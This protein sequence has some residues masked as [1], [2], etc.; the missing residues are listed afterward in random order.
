MI[1]FM[2]RTKPSKTNVKKVLE[3]SR[4]VPFAGNNEWKGTWSF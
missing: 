4:L 2:E 1:S 3:V